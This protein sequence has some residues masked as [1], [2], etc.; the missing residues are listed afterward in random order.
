MEA[1]NQKLLINR[2]VAA[3]HKEE[4]ARRQDEKLKEL[5]IEIEEKKKL[6]KEIDEERKNILLEKEKLVQKNKE[7]YTKQ[8]NEFKEYAEIIKEEQ[9]IE[10]ERKNDIIRQIRELEKIPTIRFKGFDPSETPGYGLLEE[11]SLVELRERLAQQKKFIKEYE[12]SKREENKLK[13]EEKVENLLEKA[14]IISDTRDKLK[15][16]KE[17]ERKQ[18]QEQLEK[19]K[20]IK[21]EIRERSLLEVKGKIEQKKQKMREEEKELE[22]KIRELKLQRQ[23]LKQGKV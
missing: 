19:E 7:N 13:A 17:K 21:Q 11:M 20:R 5:E 12:E 1:Y 6:I 23:F 10:Q 9:R 2:T 14:K 18:K 16:Q 3:K 22:L 15:Q 8:I 4:E